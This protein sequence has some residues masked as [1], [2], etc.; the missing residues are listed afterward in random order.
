[1]KLTI[2]AITL[3][4]VFAAAL[5]G[6]GFASRDAKAKLSFEGTVMK[7]GPPIFRSGFVTAYRLVKYRV[8]RV[9]T[10]SYQ[11]AEIVVDHLVLT[12]KELDGV[13]VGD[14][15]YV[16]LK[17]AKKISPRYN[18][19]GIREASDKLNVFYIGGTVS[20]AATSSCSCQ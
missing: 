6:S 3:L 7:I 4:F 16:T 8:E 9:C 1:M 13:N 15:V 14:R 11:Q 2:T 19:A 18:V 10:G 20:S 12:G 5:Q 17:K